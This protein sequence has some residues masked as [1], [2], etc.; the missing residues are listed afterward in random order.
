MQIVKR[1]YYTN[2]EIQYKF[3]GF[4][5]TKEFGSG[6]RITVHLNMTRKTIAF[7]INGVR[8]PE[9]TAW[10]NLPSRLYPVVSLR[11]PGRIRFI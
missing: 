10:L 7:S 5:Y 6:T 8:H 9:I 4:E 11:P 2:Q 1:K 3:I